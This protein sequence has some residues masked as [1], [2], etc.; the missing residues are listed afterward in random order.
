MAWILT[1]NYARL[2]RV[3]L[4]NEP[5]IGRLDGVAKIEDATNF[6]FRPADGRRRDPVERTPGT[7]IDTESITQIPHAGRDGDSPGG[8]ASSSVLNDF[9]VGVEDARRRA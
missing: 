4:R 1:D 7:R 8:D 5:K 3:E 6:R 9:V 2:M